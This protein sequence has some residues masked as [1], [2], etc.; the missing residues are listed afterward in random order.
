VKY[1]LSN[2]PKRNEI[3]KNA[4][5]KASENYESE[6]CF[7]RCSVSFEIKLDRTIITEPD[8]IFER[9]FQDKIS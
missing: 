8:I 9:R 1:Y 5:K 4:Y 7:K 3:A 6:V 2:E